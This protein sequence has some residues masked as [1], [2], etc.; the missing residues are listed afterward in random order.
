MFFLFQKVS[1]F[2]FFGVSQLISARSL[3]FFHIC[4]AQPAAQ[5]RPPAAQ[6]GPFWYKGR[7][8]NLIEVVLCSFLLCE[9]G[10]CVCFWSWRRRRRRKTK[11][12]ASWGFYSH[13]ELQRLRESGRRR[14]QKFQQPRQKQ[15]EDRRATAQPVLRR[16]DP[17]PGS[18]PSSKGCDPA[19]SPDPD[20]RQV[21]TGS[22]AGSGRVRHHLSVYG[23]RDEAGPGLQVHIQ[24]QAQNRGTEAEMRKRHVVSFAC[25]CNFGFVL[26]RWI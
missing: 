1:F 18:D 20:R 8:N 11:K 14:R 26:F 16:P 2:S 7:R 10:L 24:T 9:T 17:V 5:P 25:F 15:E 3:S 23:P 4:H 22:R 13:G 19:R 6:N 21:H 12:L